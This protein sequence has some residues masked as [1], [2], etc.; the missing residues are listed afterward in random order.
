MGCGA[1]QTACPYDVR[2]LA[3][4]EDGYF[5]PEL[6]EYETV[7]YEAMPPA[8]MDKCTFCA[9]RIDAGAGEKQACVAACPAGARVFGELDD[10]RA[11]AE[12]AGGYQ[13]L[14]EEGTNPSVWYLPHKV[15]E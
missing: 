2:H 14:P 10:L 9:E 7:M 12:A 1:C 3:A 6:N 4:S 15:N 8:T 13:L 11:Q 5:G